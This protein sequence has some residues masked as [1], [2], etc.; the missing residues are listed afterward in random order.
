MENIRTPWP[1]AWT[2]HTHTLAHTYAQTNTDTHTL[3]QTLHTHKLKH[4]RTHTLK[5]TFTA[6]LRIISIITYIRSIFTNQYCQFC[7]QQV[8]SVAIISLSCVLSVSCGDWKFMATIFLSTLCRL[9][10]FLLEERSLKPK[11]LLLLH[12]SVLFM[13]VLAQKY[14][15]E[16]FCFREEYLIGAKQA[17]VSRNDI[18]LFRDPWPSAVWIQSYG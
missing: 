5:H 1:P 17:W 13:C 7:P 16:K 15:Y 4:T 11:P 6:W 10:L 2:R 18:R 3:K 12:V 14:A 8:G 9:F